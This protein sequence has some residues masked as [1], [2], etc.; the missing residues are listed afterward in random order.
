MYRFGS[1][2]LALGALAVSY[3]VETNAWVQSDKTDFE[4]GNL[5]QLSL[6]SDG[7]LFL[8]PVQRELLDTSTTYLWAAAADSKGNVYVGGGGPGASNNKVHRIDPQGKSSVLAELPG[9]EIHAIAIDR[10][11]QVFA[12]TSP[13]GKVYRISAPNKADVFYDPKAKYIW[14]MTFNR[15]GDLFVATGDQ[16]E[17]HRVSQ[18]GKGSVFFKTDDTHARSLTVDGKDNLIVG[19]EPSGLVVRVSPKA[20]G[21][22][23]YQAN[24]REITAVAMAPDGAIYAAGVGNKQPGGTTPAPQI[25]LAPPAPAP[26][27]AAPMAPAARTTVTA[28]PPASL[29]VG[30]P[31]IAGG[32]E[33][34]RIDAEGYAR[35]VWSDA[36]DI[37][38]TLTFD[39]NGKPLLGTGNKGNIYRIDSDLQSTLLLSALPTQITGLLTGPA[40]RIYAITGNIGK[41]YQIGPDLEKEGTIE[42]DVFDAGSF[43]QWGRLVHRGEGTIR[44]ETRSGNLDRPQKN[45]SAWAPVPLTNGGGRTASPA[46]R[47]VQW[48]ATLVNGGARTPELS[49]VEV[50]YLPKNVA[51][52][53]EDV[54]VTQA[55]Y[56]FPTPAVTINPSST[57]P[58]L[59]LPPIGQRK[60][61]SPTPVA[62]DAGGTLQYAKGFRAARW[63]AT[64]PNNDT[65][66]FT[67]EIRGVNETEWKLLKDKVRERQ[68]TWDTTAYPDGDYVLRVTASDAPGNPPGQELTS[69]FVSDPFTVDNTAPVIS[70]LAGT[71]SG[72]R[73]TFKWKARDGRGTIGKAEYSL[74][75]GEWLI[76]EPSTR[77]SDA[78]EHDYTLTI[79]RPTPGEQTIAVR[80]TDWYDNQSVEKAV[81]K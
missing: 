38:Y 49:Y 61:L 4:K 80:V 53:V 48:K 41:V 69:R 52:V 47:F 37:V 70:G 15:A 12:A 45:W 73:L 66:L 30:P 44:F 20:E 43:T 26:A 63:A 68:I 7:R 57:P 40:G 25:P 32:S 78:P 10:K 56:R 50:A 17:L 51:P 81:L 23:V 9:L 35:R 72:N 64:D 36:S 55:N 2:L 29:V 27:A 21:F 33:V 11:D 62:V 31:S 8:A 34:Y 3:A 18:D 71:A 46:A 58:A 54:E 39:A 5:K 24:K 75:G 76:V 60:R 74:N 59:T 42:S 13:D 79:D 19:T 28:A 16:G 14:A 6:R 67:V 65:M 1:L 22:V 77:L